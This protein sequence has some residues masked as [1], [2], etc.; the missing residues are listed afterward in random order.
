[1]EKNENSNAWTTIEL[2]KAGN[3]TDAWIRQL[4][5]NGEIDGYKLGR[6]WRIP[7]STAIEW[8]HKRGIVVEEE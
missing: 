3:V 6:D 1:M 2:A 5:I 7:E 4:L 8:L